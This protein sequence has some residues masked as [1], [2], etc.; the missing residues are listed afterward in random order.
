[1]PLAIKTVYGKKDFIELLFQH[2]LGGAPK[3]RGSE[4]FTAV[5]SPINN[6][7]TKLWV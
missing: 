2:T 1:M 6:M 3:L 7:N 4:D 5:F